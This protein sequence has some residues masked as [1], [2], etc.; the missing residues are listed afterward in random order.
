MTNGCIEY[1][2]Q[3]NWAGYSRIYVKGKQITAHRFS[4]QINIGE[5]PQGMCVCHTCDNRSCVNPMHLFLGTSKEN[6]QDMMKKGRKSSNVGERNPC[7]I[8][9][10]EQ[11]KFIRQKRLDG[12]SR[13]EIAKQFNCSIHTVINIDLKRSWRH[14]L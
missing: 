6:T 14:I 4:Y 13:K 1:S 5:I 8:F 11:I 2:G 3:K 10:D 12:I 9:T 7:S